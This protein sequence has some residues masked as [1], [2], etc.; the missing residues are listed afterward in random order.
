MQACEFSLSS[1]KIAALTNAGTGQV[2]LAL[3]GFLDNAASMTCLAPYFDDYH[4]VAIDLAGHGRSFHRAAGAHYNQIDYIQDI[5]Q[6][7]T[8]QGWDDVILIGHS[9]GGILASLYAASFPE[10]VSAMACIDALGPLTLPADTSVEQIRASVESR[11]PKPKR[12]GANRPINLESAIKARC[13]VSDTRPEHARVILSRN[14]AGNEQDGYYWCS[15]PRL[16]TKSTLRLTEQQ[17]QNVLESIT[18]PVWVGGATDSF[19]TL[20]KVYEKRKVWL[21]NSKFELFSGGHH[22]H[23]VNPR[24]VGSAIRKFVEEM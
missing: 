24:A 12:S 23:M 21:K 7:I 14:L 13:S 22:F 1:G 16:R 18:C 4:F 9:L 10:K 19:K 6:L 2:V 8:E 17:A 11:L 3:H 5:H 20:A 15:D